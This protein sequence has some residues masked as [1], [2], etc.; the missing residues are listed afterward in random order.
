MKCNMVKKLLSEYID[1]ALDEQTGTLIEAH[2]KGCKGCSNEYTSIKIMIGELRSM[3]SFEAPKDFLEKV[4]DRIDTMAPVEKT[5]SFLY[6]P[7]LIKNPMEL[8]ALAATAVLIFIIFNTVKPE[9]QAIVRPPA[10]EITESKV[11]PEKDTKEDTEGSALTTPFPAKE[12]GPIQLALLLGPEQKPTPLSSENV[13][14]IVSGKGP[15]TVLD[16]PELGFGTE[17]DQEIDHQVDEDPLSDIVKTISISE[18][19]LVSKEYKNGTDEP[20]YITLEIPIINYHPFLEKIRDI[21]TL[22]A[23]AP[24]LPEGYNG[25]VL[26]RVQLISSE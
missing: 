3:G 23:P 20:E 17:L 5:R 8:I 11:E 1:N 26:L 12:I 15:E 24:D 25:P 9:K 16:N 18:G 13:R 6:F 4:H 2:L 19:R 21:G 7:S 14:L 22:R 10:A